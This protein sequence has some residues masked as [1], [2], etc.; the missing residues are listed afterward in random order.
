MTTLTGILLTLAIIML[1]GIL[2]FWVIARALYKRVRRSRVLT[3]AMLRTRA[4]LSRGPQHE[5]LKLRL[6]LEE[7]LDSG[8]A[9]VDLALRS[10]GPSGELPRLFRR[11]EEEGGTLDAQL[12][13]MAS[14]TDSAVLAEGI[15][16]AGRRVDQV[17]G[18][19]RRLRSAVAAGLG[20]L[21]D[22]TLTTLRSDVDHEVAALSAGVR[23]LRT[24]NGYDGLSDSRRQLSMDRMVRGNES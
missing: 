14:E 3:G 8:Q 13:L 20:D 19:V 5:I 11:I 18:L 21:T 6:R 10:A 1:A 9:A 22:D 24:L 15:P 4:R 12:R 2:T 17:A 23:E 7:A 16:V